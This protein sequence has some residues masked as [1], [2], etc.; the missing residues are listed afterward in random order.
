MTKSFKNQPFRTKVYNWFVNIFGIN[1]IVGILS[2]V[3]AKQI[4]SS[5][6]TRKA[7][8]ELIRRVD[9]LEAH[10]FDSEISKLESELNDAINDWYIAESKK[11]SNSKKVKKSTKSKK[12]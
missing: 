9:V 8:E 2:D 5:A 4:L 7:I 1:A 3:F 10:L 12:K 6:E 11:I